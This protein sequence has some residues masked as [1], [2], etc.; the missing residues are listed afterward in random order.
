MIELKRHLVGE[1]ALGKSEGSLQ[2]LSQSLPLLV[3]LDCSQNLFV[4]LCLVF[5]PLLGGLVTF[6]L[7]VE[8]VTFLLGGLLSLD[9]GKVFV[10]DGVRDLDSRHVDLGGRGEEESL[11]HS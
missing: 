8:D 4:N 9:P 11:V 7:G 2:I 6:L 5:L 10:I 3:S 1:L